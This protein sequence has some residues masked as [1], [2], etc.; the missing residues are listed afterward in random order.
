MAIGQALLDAKWIQS[1]TSHE[2]IFCD[3]YALYRAGK[4]SLFLKEGTTSLFCNTLSFPS[5]NFTKGAHF[6]LGKWWQTLW[7]MSV[8]SLL[9]FFLWLL[10]FFC[11]WGWGGEVWIGPKAA[12][13]EIKEPT[14]SSSQC[15][16]LANDWPSRAIG[17]LYLSW[18]LFDKIPT[19]KLFL[20]K[21]II[22]FLLKLDCSDDNICKRLR[23]DPD[24]GRRVGCDWRQ[25]GT[26]LVP[27]DRSGRQRQPDRWRW[28]RLASS[29]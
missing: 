7:L 12:S 21:T 20:K 19:L 3:E 9:N 27:R 23:R 5:S 1:A 8:H 22:F 16:F 15:R 29:N 14:N 25:D 28:S 4:V 2:K 24:R 10:L 26:K 17:S 13:F 11:L 6:S 18:N